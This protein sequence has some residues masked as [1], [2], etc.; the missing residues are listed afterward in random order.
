MPDE[1]KEEAPQRLNPFMGTSPP[2]GEPTP[3]SAEVVQYLREQARLGDEVTR[4]KREIAIVRS[5]VDTDH[6]LGKLFIRALERSDNWENP[7]WTPEEIR[8]TAAVYD[9]PM[10]GE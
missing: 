6:P 4:M 2:V 5:G 7:D 8:A 1:P 10:R 3:E 9:V